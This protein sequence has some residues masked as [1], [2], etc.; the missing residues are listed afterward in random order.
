L[1]HQRKLKKETEVEKGETKLKSGLT[2]RRPPLKVRYAK[3]RTNLS[4]MLLGIQL[5]L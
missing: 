3:S 2:E 5:G 1:A 4:P